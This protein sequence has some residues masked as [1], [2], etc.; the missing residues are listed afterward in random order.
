MNP[1]SI[2]R[3]L[4]RSGR[5]EAGDYPKSR[6]K[7]EKMFIKITGDINVG[8]LFGMA[9]MAVLASFL[10]LLTGEYREVSAQTAYVGGQQAAK[11]EV[12]QQSG[13]IEFSGQ[14]VSVDPQTGK[15]REPSPEEAGRLSEMIRE[16]AKKHRKSSD[17]LKAYLY[18][19]GTVSVELTEDYMDVSVV[20]INSDGTLS[21]ECITGMKAAGE[22][23]EKGTTGGAE[24]RSD[25]NVSVKPR[26][27]LEEK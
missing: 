11:S 16:F 23:V 15:L 1:F 8:R 25:G 6:I 10:L 13:A 7:G 3:A 19:D 17:G 4:V 21:M 14:I 20:R 27:E 18:T 9:L 12:Q 22:A 2:I 24:K 26:S 5:G